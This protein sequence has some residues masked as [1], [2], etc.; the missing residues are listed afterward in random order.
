M[1]PA[2]AFS[3]TGRTWAIS[4]AIVA[5]FMG[6]AAIQPGA[7]AALTLEDAVRLAVTTNPTT[8]AADSGMRAAAM[9]LLELERAYRP[10]LS[11][12][13]EAGVAWYDDPDRLAPGDE[14]A[15]RDYNEVGVLAEYTLFDGY[16]RANSVYRNAARLDGAILR[17]L[18]ASETMALSAVEAYVDVMRHRDLLRVA[19]QSVARHRELAAQVDDLV[20]SGRLPASASFEAEERVLAARLGTIEVR[21]ALRDAE[22]R[23]RAVI[24]RDPGGAMTVPGLANLPWDRQAYILASARESYR[25][26]ERDRAI[27]ERRYDSAV[28]TAD[29]RPQVTLEGGLRRGSNIG[30]T[31]G[32]EEDAFVALRFNWQFYAGGRDARERALE[33]RTREARARHEAA[34]REIIAIAERAWNGWNAATERAILVNERRTAVEDTAEEYAAEFRAGSRTLLEVLDAERARFNITL[35]AVSADASHLFAQYRL[36]AGQSRLARHFGLTAADVALAPDF[37]PSATQ[38]ARAQDIFNTEIRA[39][40]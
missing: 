22:A 10:T 5:S 23:F 33:Y 32:I 20:Q 38:G 24:G 31:T 4:P 25:L 11:L 30:G 13:G 26:Q 14:D 29:T 1:K 15:V 40:D 36:L 18:D 6:W 35:E 37:L 21:Q 39:L 7:A 2:K 19:N 28:V 9:E 34:R 17:L 8:R 27:D 16:R 3:R 12:Y